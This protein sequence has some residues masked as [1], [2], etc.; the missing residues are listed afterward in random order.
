MVYAFIG[1]LQFGLQQ[2]DGALSLG[3]VFNPLDLKLILVTRLVS[4]EQFEP[5][6]L[7]NVL[8]LLVVRL[9]EIVVVVLVHVLDLSLDGSLTHMPW[10]DQFH[11]EEGAETIVRLVFAEFSQNVR[12]LLFSVL[13]LPALVLSLVHPD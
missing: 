9:E 7:L 1:E 4:T 11:L 3:V 13:P 5:S 6:E 8:T 12:V 10:L 2:F